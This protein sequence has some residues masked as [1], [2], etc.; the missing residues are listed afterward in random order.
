[1]KLLCRSSACQP[2][3]SRLTFYWGDGMNKL[4][5][6]INLAAN[7]AIILVVVLIGIVFVKNYLPSIYSRHKNRDYRVS[8]GRNVSL[9]SVDWENNGETLL[10]VLDTK[11][12]YCRASAPFY[13]EIAR[14]A[15]QNH[16]VQ[17]IAVLPQSISESKQYL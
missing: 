12:G 2:F 1:M 10:L 9:P 14:E 5:K 7:L 8:A 4:N 15:S 6:R 17:L 11:C 16:G 3:N 13:Q